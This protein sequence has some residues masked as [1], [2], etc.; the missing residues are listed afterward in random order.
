MRLGPDFTAGYARWNKS[1]IVP[2]LLP[3]PTFLSR[4]STL[5]TDAPAHEQKPQGLGEWS[6]FAGEG[7]LSQQ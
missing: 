7:D 4:I 1:E 2:L 3:R 5:I 6:L